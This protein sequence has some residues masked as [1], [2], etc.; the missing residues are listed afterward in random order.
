MR[1]KGGSFGFN[2]ET[3]QFADLVKDGVIDPTK[4]VR[5]ALE[6]GSSVARVL[7]STDVCV[8]EKPKEKDEGDVPPGM[9]EDMDY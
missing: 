4:V 2:A 1:E 3:G 9:D 6:N 5:I 7:L 8:S